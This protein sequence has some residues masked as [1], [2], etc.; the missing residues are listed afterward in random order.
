[1]RVIQVISDGK[2]KESREV[3]GEERDQ[4]KTFHLKKSGG[5]W[6]FCTG[7]FKEQDGA[8]RLT[9]APIEGSLQG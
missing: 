9:F 2:D 7:S 8:R 4:K 5:I 3:I 6:H 1:M